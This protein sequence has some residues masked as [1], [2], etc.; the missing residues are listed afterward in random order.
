MFW[1]GGSDQEEDG[2][3][4]WIDDSVFNLTE[5][6]W[7]PDQPDNVGPGCMV[8]NLDKLFM[9]MECYW[10]Y[11]TPNEERPCY[12]QCPPEH[13]IFYLCAHNINNPGSRI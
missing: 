10:K 12:P 4:K 3:F 2:N 6:N 8:M 7:A 9:D 11:D 13:D 5:K 1:V